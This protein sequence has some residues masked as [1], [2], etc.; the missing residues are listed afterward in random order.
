M[1]KEHSAHGGPAVEATDE[2]DHAAKLRA[3]AILDRTYHDPTAVH[4][5]DAE[6]KAEAFAM[7]GRIP[8]DC[9]SCQIEVIDYLRSMLGLHSIKREAPPALHRQRLDVCRGNA[10]KG[11]ERCEH[12][13]WPGMNCG[14]C[15]CFIDVKARM[16]GMRCP[17]NKWIK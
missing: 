1:L 11:I 8:S 4:W 12:L 2:G 14:L 3:Q 7:A 16:R 10:K 9:P 17:E 15:G 5:P 13:A 6:T